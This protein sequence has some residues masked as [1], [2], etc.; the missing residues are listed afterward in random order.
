MRGDVKAVAD[1][2]PAETLADAVEWLESLQAG[3]D[4][5]IYPTLEELSK[6]VDVPLATLK[7]WRREKNMP[8]EPGRW[9]V[10]EFFQ[11][12]MRDMKP[13]SSFDRRWHEVLP[14]IHG[15]EL[16]LLGPDLEFEA[17]STFEPTIPADVPDVVRE[18]ILKEAGRLT[19]AVLET[20][21]QQAAA[22][23]KHRDESEVLDDADPA[24]TD[25]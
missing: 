1:M 3:S 11:W 13:L 22:R 2:I 14:I 18:F 17:G 15:V 23:L 20:I 9:S 24:P 8:G 25:E 7:K 19:A 10:Q 5:W 16:T 4:R 12:Q 21:R 6:A